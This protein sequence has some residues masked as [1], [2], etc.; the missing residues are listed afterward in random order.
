M[1]VSIGLTL[2]WA[3][4]PQPPGARLFPRA[5][6]V[7]HAIAFATILGTFLLAGVWRPGRGWGRFAGAVAPA[8][9]VMLASGI[10]IEIVQGELFGRDADILDILAEIV[11][12]IAAVSLV[13]AWGWATA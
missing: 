3:F 7:L 1:V 9:V 8:L 6:K 13:R 12:M 2:F 4:G 11:G 5:D 10:V